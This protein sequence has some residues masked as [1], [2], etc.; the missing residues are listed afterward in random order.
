MQHS[1]DDEA[2]SDEEIG[3]EGY[4]QGQ[5]QY[6][7]TSLHEPQAKPIFLPQELCPRVAQGE[8]EA[9][10]EEKER[11]CGAGHRQPEAGGYINIVDGKIVEIEYQMVENHEDDGRRA[12]DHSRIF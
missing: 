7:G 4:S 5:A 9:D 11:G 3:N 10:E 1:K 2:P 6:P 8:G 12:L